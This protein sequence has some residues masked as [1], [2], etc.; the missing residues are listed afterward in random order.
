MNHPHY[1]SFE[2]GV[3][4]HH[5]HDSLRKSLAAVERAQHCALLWFSEISR[6]GLF[7]E[8]GYSSMVSYASEELG[9][10]AVKIRDFVRLARKLEELPR[11]KESVARGEV[12]YTK[13]REV[14]KVATP[15]TEARWVAEATKSSRK[16][17]AAKVAQVRKTAQVRRA[18]P[19]QP[20]LLPAAR[21]DA[22]L[23]R[24]VPVRVGMEMSPEQFARYEALWE[25][26]YK[27]DG[28]PVGS[29]KADVLLEALA[30]RVAEVERG[31]LGDASTC[32]QCNNTTSA[33]RVAHQ[34]HIHQC[35]DCEQATVQTSAGEKRLSAE[36]VDRLHCDAVITRPGRRAGATIPPKIRREV[37]NRDRRRCQGA[38]CTH[39]RF[40]EIHHKRPVSRGGGNDP[41]NL[42]TL[43]GACHRLV[44]ESRNIILNLSPSLPVY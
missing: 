26:L 14:I 37:L 38:G 7:R 2:A 6:R 22:E 34:I 13:A 17:L 19:T 28:V 21:I 41:D 9:F 43:C 25:K 12:G 30:G 40:L 27:L 1:A 15:K 10:S 24:E 3:P 35:L 16:V 33:P 31:T 4:A 11:L 5:A 23:I 42:I 44:H 39:T 32:N 18:N 20:E 8:L 29:N 36:T